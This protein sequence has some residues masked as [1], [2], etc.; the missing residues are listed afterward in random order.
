[1]QW[2]ISLFFLIVLGAAEILLSQQ[3]PKAQ[4]GAENKPRVKVQIVP[5]EP[6]L[7]TGDCKSSTGGY[8]SQDGRTVLTD[9]EIGKFVSENLH[10]GYVL[11]M[12]P[13]TKNGVFVVAD[14]T[15]MMVLT[16]Q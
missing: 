3:P 8:L 2:K 15:N 10:H 11:T 7:P 13:E 12:Y 16:V 4:I 5:S 1:M 9:S 14:C 6:I